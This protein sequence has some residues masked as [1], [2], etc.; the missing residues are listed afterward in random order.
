VIPS[1]SFAALVAIDSAEGLVAA[2]TA[3]IVALFAIATS[4]ALLLLA[5][6]LMPNLSERASIR[7]GR[8]HGICLL[9]G[10][11]SLALAFVSVAVA[12]P[13]PLLGVAG[14]ALLTPVY[15]LG[16]ASA[17]EGLGRRIFF[18]AG[19]ESS[20][21]LHLLV[22]WPTLVLVACIPGLGWGIGIYAAI[23]GTGSAIVALFAKDDL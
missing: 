8:R 19:R 16:L 10:L 20:R 5:V 7:F 14:L 23:A 6:A 2:A 12:K 4:L 1:S 9:A 13:I 21:P 18:L 15:V 11:G 22:G 3:A 17:G